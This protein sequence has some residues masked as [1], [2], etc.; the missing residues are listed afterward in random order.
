M[1]TLVDSLML[2]GWLLDASEK[3]ECARRALLQCAASPKNERFLRVALE[4]TQR[5]LLEIL[6][7]LSRCGLIHYTQDGKWVACEHLSR[8]WEYY[9]G[10]V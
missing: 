9:G 8:I 7:V 2:A 3:R 10:E 1:K 6:S 4:L 5:D